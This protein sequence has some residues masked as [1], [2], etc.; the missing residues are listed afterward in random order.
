MKK[1][2][3]K[4]GK[5]GPK[6][7][8]QT[9]THLFTNSKV[10]KNNHTKSFNINTENLVNIFL[11]SVLAASVSLNYMTSAQLTQK[12][13]FFWFPLSPLALIFFFPW[14][15]LFSGKMDWIE[16]SHL[17]LCIPRSLSLN[18]VWLWVSSSFSFAAGQSVFDDA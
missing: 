11:C 12:V 1:D 3:T 17:E 15:S 14:R 10:S 18:N 2:K 9:R 6:K 16:K 13:L 7:R 5:R 4:R 8:S